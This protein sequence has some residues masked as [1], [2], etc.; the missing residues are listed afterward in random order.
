MAGCRLAERKA[1]SGATDSAELVDGLK[2]R[3]QVEVEA[4]Q[5]EHGAALFAVANRS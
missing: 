2:D 1:I 5:I 4:A 3:Q